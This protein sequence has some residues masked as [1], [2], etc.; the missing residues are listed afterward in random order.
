MF[1]LSIYMDWKF[2]EEVLQ[3][4]ATH[5]NTRIKNPKKIDIIQ[6]A[7]NDASYLD[8][9]NTELLGDKTF[10]TLRV[11][12][13][14]ES[15]APYFYG[16]GACAGYSLFLSRLLGKLGFETKII[17]L[18]VKGV[19]GGHITLGI[20]DGNRLLLVDPL[21]NLAYKDSSGNLVDIHDVAKNWNNYYRYQV[22]Q[23]YNLKYD[24]QEGWRFTNWD[25]FGSFSRGIY[26]IGVFIF[27]KKKVDNF[28]FASEFSGLS[29]S[30]FVIAFL[31]F[32]VFTS[33]L[34][35]ELFLKKQ[36]I[37]KKFKKMP[38]PEG[39]LI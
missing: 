35:K 20:V 18:K 9:R 24:Y 11:Y 26:K 12:L 22:P 32:L 6:S 29:R 1:S 39:V 27:G 25:K 5:V 16:G 2:E 34:I 7:L 30:Y 8:E 28:S 13:M 19:P 38:K 33:F 21:Y 36:V 10:N 14:S 17:Q 37:I 3:N 15:F 31:G 4:L 23:N